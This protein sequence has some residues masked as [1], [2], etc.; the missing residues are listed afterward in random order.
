V[1]EIFVVRTINY[2][3]HHNLIFCR[4]IEVIKQGRKRW[5]KRKIECLILTFG[6]A[7]W[8][9]DINYKFKISHRHSGRVMKAIIIG[10]SL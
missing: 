1:T 7:C 8:K 2:E 6:R 3:I 5:Q 10:S 9:D 4:V